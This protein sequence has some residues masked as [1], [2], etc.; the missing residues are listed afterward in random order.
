[1]NRRKHRERQKRVWLLSCDLSGF[2]VGLMSAVGDVGQN[3]WQS[4]R[5]HFHHASFLLSSAIT[6][7][8][9][10]ELAIAFRL[11]DDGIKSVAVIE[12]GGFYQDAGI[13]SSPRIC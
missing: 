1:M 2:N 9:T 6:V 7:A 8:F 3:P 11:A 12:A 10:G 4:I 5:I 13:I